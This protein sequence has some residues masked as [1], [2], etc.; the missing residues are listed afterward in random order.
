MRVKC[1][2]SPKSTSASDET[3]EI[4]NPRNLVPLDPFSSTA[5]YRRVVLLCIL[6]NGGA[7][8]ETTSRNL[9][10]KVFL[11]DSSMQIPSSRL[12]FMSKFLLVV[13]A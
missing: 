12:I 2:D 13:S 5:T 7:Y 11:L 1:A 6:L 8:A 9:E 4:H 3:V 10:M